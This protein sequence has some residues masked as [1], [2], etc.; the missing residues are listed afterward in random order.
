MRVKAGSNGQTKDV[1]LF[2]VTAQN[3]IV[4]ER[5]K[6]LY[7][8]TIELVEFDRKNGKRL[9]TPRLQKFGAKSFKSFISNDLR[10]QGYTLTVLH[11]PVDYL[12]QK[13]AADAITAKQRAEAAAEAHKQAEE[14]RHAAEEARIAAAVERIVEA[15]LAAINEMQKA[16]K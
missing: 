8:C 2:E 6:H 4:P 7:H 13:E 14:A 12:K 5:E 9:S 16:K 15:R 11:D 3:Y 1:T 10:K